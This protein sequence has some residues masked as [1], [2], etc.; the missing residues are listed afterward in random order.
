MALS[1]AWSMKQRG[2]QPIHNV[3]RVS[4]GNERVR[5]AE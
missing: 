4:P 3:P 5:V 2:A 1:W